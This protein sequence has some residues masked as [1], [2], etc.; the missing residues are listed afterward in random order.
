MPSTINP[1]R[2]AILKKNLLAGKSAIESLKASGYTDNYAHRS[3]TAKCVKVCNAEIQ[4]DIKK[5]INVDYVLAELERIKK[6]AE[7]DKDFSTATRNVELL[8]K[9]LTMF[10]DRT[11]LAQ[12]DKDSNQFGLN[13][14]SKIKVEN[15]ENIA[16][17]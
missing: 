14:L 12:V 11:E 6:L 10:T 7:E 9:Y 16:K 8:G 4:E 17:G 5:K 1:I 15:D 13:R 2:K 3:T